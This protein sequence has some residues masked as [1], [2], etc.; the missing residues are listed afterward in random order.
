[1][2]NSHWKPEQ[3]GQKKRKVSLPEIPPDHVDPEAI[4]GFTIEQ[5]A[6]ELAKRRQE[7]T[8]GLLE[9]VHHCHN[10]ELG[11]YWTN[12]DGLAF[13]SANESQMRCHTTVVLP[14]MPCT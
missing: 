4:G 12:N 6:A 13:K 1:M 11:E 8:P 10:A 14:S 3:N 2:P 7:T 9:G 5:L